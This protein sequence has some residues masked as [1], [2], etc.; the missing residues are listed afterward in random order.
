MGPYVKKYVKTADIWDTY[1]LFAGRVSHFPERYCCAVLMG[2]VA[3]L[4]VC[5]YT[6]LCLALRIVRVIHYRPNQRQRIEAL[7]TNACFPTCY[8]QMY[9]LLLHQITA[10]HWFHKRFRIRGHDH[11][12]ATLVAGSTFHSFIIL[13][14]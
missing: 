14:Q 3:R 2:T 9:Q 11:F 12:T 13:I 7:G 5:L 8:A 10:V 6:S 4:R 1:C